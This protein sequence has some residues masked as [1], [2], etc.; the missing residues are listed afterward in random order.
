MDEEEEYAFPE[1]NRSK[2]PETKRSNLKSKSN[3]V[4]PSQQNEE[5]RKPKKSAQFLA[6]SPSPPNPLRKL[7]QNMLASATRGRSPSKSR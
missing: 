2:Q 6:P 4:T 5:K 3:L 1:T 7:S